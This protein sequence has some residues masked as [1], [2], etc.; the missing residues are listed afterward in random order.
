MI[1]SMDICIPVGTPPL[2]DIEPKMSPIES[3]I[4]RSSGPVIDPLPV[5]RIELDK[6]LVSMKLAFALSALIMP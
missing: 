5:W 3:R 2:K 4:D 6:V 1:E